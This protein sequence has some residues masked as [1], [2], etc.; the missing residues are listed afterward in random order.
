MLPILRRNNGVSLFDDIFGDSLDSFFDNDWLKEFNIR[1]KSNVCYH[2][3]EED[4]EHVI[5]VQ[6]P[7]FK[8]DDINIE[9]DESGIYLKGEVNDES[10]RNKINRS[11]F[12][13]A[14]RIRG[15]NDKSID[16][17][18]EDGILTVKFKTLEPKKKT[19]KQIEIKGS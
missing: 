7:G 10:V 2:F 1:P 5:D 15:I 14:M 18:L 16:A 4:K 12:S 3:N 19:I 13:Y 6:V 17:S 11:Q 8:K 9:V